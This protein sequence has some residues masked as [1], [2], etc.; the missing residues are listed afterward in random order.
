MDDTTAPPAPDRSRVTPASLA[1]VLIDL[2]ERP[3]ARQLLEHG[4]TVLQKAQD[5]TPHALQLGATLAPLL[6]GEQ[7][8]R[9]LA[10]ADRAL[11]VWRGQDYWSKE[12]QALWAWRK[13]QRAA[14]P[15][16]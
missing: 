9:A 7:P 4:L 3:R 14:P 15:P 10:L 12:Y 2:R 16:R 8:A 5:T 1:S 13:K 6:V 11:A